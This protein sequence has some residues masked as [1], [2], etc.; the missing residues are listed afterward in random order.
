MEGAGNLLVIG[1]RI[2]V[3][4]AHR[5]E[6]LRGGVPPAVGAPRV[7]HAVL[8]HVGQRQ[9]VRLGVFRTQVQAEGEGGV[10]VIRRQARV[11]VLA[12]ESL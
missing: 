7:A 12:V 4:L 3:F 5:D 1:Q 9:V 8:V 2:V 10:V 6:L 11:A